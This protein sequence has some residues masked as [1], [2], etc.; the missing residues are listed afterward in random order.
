MNW[1]LIWLLTLLYR[2]TQGE[3]LERA[4][5]AQWKTG[6]SVVAAFGLFSGLLIPLFEKINPHRAFDTWL[7]VTI[8]CSISFFAWYYLIRKLPVILLVIIGVAGWL[9]MAAQSFFLW[10]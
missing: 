2:I 6:I 5:P 1:T 3:R 9:M 8:G 10:K 7:L 4:T